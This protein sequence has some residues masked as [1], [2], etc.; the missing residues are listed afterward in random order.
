MLIK[1]KDRI[2]GIGEVKGFVFTKEFENDKGYVY[3]V[4]SGNTHYFEAFHKKEANV[5]IDFSNRVYSNT[6]KKEMYPKAKHF[7]L[8]AWTV[9]SVEKGVD[10]LNED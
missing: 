10:R 6:E 3:R 7:G 9:A 1:L 2:E 8:W 4:D 5:C